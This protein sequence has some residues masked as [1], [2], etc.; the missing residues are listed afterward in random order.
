MKSA[1]DDA[2]KAREDKERIENQ[3]QAYAN[4]V[5]P[6]ARGEAAR[7][8]ENAKAYRARIIAEA[9]GE[10]DRFLALL[11][12]YDKAPQVTRQRLYLETVEN[13]YGN[14]SKVLLDVEGG[15]NLTY[16]PLDQIIQ[17]QRVLRQPASPSGLTSDNPPQETQP[18]VALPRDVDR[19]RRVR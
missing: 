10:S 5:V 14:T 11:R 16:L 2:I 19:S 3:A 8:L 18:Q 6:V 7:E 4:E 17:R 1:F 9:R 15:S 12:E 13:V